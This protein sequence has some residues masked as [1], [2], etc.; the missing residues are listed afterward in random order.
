[1]SSSTGS[2]AS[3]T[4]IG[5]LSSI[6]SS[7]SISCTIPGG[8]I[9][10]TA[11]RIRVVSSLP[12]VVGSD[13]GTNL[14]MIGTLGSTG[15]ISGLASVCQG[16]SGVV[17]STTAVSNASNYAWSLPLGFTII[18]GTGTN[19]IT[20]NIA[21]NASSGSITVTP[22][23]VCTTGTISSA[24][25]VSVSQLPSAAGVISGNTSVCQGDQN[26][27]YTVPSILF[28]T[29]YSWSFPVGF[30]IIGTPTN[31]VT[32]NVAPGAASGTISVYG[33]NSCGNGGSSSLAIA[34]S[35]APSAAI[36]SAGGPLTV[37]SPNSVSMSFAPSVGVDYQ[38]RLNGIDLSGETASV[39]VATQTGNYD[40]VSN[41]AAVGSQQF[42]TSVPAVIPDNSCT[43]VASPI[44]VSGY[45]SSIPTSSI[46]VQMNLTHTYV[47]DLDI[48]L[49]SPTGE[50]LGLSDQTGNSNNGGDNFTNTVFA[51]SGAT[52]LPTSGAPYSDLYKPWNTVFTVNSCALTTTHT[53]FASLGGGSLNPNGTWSLKSVRSSWCRYR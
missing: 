39:Y 22:S 51:D 12:S 49:E 33:V 14:I 29:S 32:V 46:Y 9:A 41:F 8:S 17:Y 18:S 31:S 7:G 43:G 44:V 10:G 23:N 30:S 48:F 52:I 11:Y 19:S 50:R 6:S 25:P 5:T 40:V 47:G 27:T 2:F 21:A 26:L 45:T 24:Y 13:N 37:C 1:M 53:S 16:Q 4:N 42:S 35:S 34:V 38:W 20:V 28:A 3:P 36:I 15:T